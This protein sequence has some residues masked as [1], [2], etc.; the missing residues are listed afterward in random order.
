[1]IPITEKQT[2]GHNYL[3]YSEPG[4]KWKKKLDSKYDVCWW[5]I[6]VPKY[7]Y[8][9]AVIKVKFIQISPGINIHLYGSTSK[10]SKEYKSTIVAR[11]GPPEV[12]QEYQ[13]D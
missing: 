6:H 12:R 1:M 3:R 13:I 9:S 8:K 2:W 4:S 7:T 5:S 11:N 10:D